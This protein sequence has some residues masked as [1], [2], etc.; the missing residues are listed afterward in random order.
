MINDAMSSSRIIGL[1]NH[2]TAAN[3]GVAYT[4]LGAWQPQHIMK[5]RTA[6]YW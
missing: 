1:S 3:R 6:G 4:M 5:P 2:A